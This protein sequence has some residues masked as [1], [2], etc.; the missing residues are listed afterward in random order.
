MTVKQGKVRC[1]VKS[2]TCFELSCGVFLL[3]AWNN[4]GMN[5]TK[6][7]SFGIKIH[8]ELEGGGGRKGGDCKHPWG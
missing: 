7:L 8:G 1:N 4:V 6:M 2:L 5:R 3:S